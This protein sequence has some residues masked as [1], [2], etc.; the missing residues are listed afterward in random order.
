[1]VAGSH[2]ASQVSSPAAWLGFSKGHWEA[3]AKIC[4]PADCGP[5]DTMPHLGKLPRGDPAPLSP[6]SSSVLP[7]WTSLGSHLFPSS[8]ED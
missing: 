1:M 6:S 4:C 8:S 3:L 5:S 7:W 2:A